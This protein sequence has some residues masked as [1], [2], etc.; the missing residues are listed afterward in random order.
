MHVRMVPYNVVMMLI[1]VGRN[2]IKAKN[3]CDSVALHYL[4]NHITYRNHTEDAE[5]INVVL[6]EVSVVNDFIIR[7][8]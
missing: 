8:T 3:W 1:D 7:P 5:K 6:A 4:C 2:L